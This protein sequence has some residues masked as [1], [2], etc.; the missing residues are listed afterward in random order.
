MLESNDDDRKEL[1]EA[2]TEKSERLSEEAKRPGVLSAVSKKMMA[3]PGLGS[4]GEDNE[5]LAKIG[6]EALQSTGEIMDQHMIDSL[7][8][9]YPC[10]DTVKSIGDRNGG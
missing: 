4:V 8:D 3:L 1:A 7:V 9:L 5:T 2:L 6:E 10:Q